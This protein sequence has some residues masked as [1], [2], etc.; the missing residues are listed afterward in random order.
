MKVILTNKVKSLGSVGDIVNVSQGYARNYLIP[1]SFAMLADESNTKQMGDY[2]KMLAKKVD[3]EKV[4]AQEI[5]KKVSTLS[6]NIIK[7]VGGNGNLFGTV[8]NSEISK[9]LEELGV[10]I[11]RRQITIESPIKVLG[12]YDIPVKLFKGVETTIKVVVEVDPSQ[13]AEV[14]KMKADAA[15]LADNQARIEAAR[16]AAEEKA[17]GTSS[18]EVETKEEKA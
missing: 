7:K 17:L 1:Q 18:D 6:V 9:K 14:E 15:A 12:S 8:T 16:V 2:Q 5:A 10:S 3:A 13:A 11:E 4:E